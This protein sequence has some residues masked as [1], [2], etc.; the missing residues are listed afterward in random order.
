MPQGYAEGFKTYA[1][2]SRAYLGGAAKVGP[3]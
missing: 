1:K 2:K 3:I